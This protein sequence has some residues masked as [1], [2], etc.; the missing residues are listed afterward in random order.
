MCRIQTASE[1]ARWWR[2][3]PDTQSFIAYHM[4]FGNPTAIAYKRT[5]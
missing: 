1:H 3:S 4:Q 2:A 5:D